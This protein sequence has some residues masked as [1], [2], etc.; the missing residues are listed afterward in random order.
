MARSTP[1]PPPY[2]QPLTVIFLGAGASAADGA[3][4]QSKLFPDY[5]QSAAIQNRVDAEMKAAL[6]T[7]F[8]RL[9]GIDVEGGLADARFPT[10]EEVLGMLDIAEARGEAFRGFGDDPHA[11][12]LRELRNHLVALISLIL[13]EKLQGEC[14]NHR[15]L[16]QSLRSS[17]RLESASFVSLNYD[18]LI[19]NAIERASIDDGRQAL[20]DYG[21]EFTPQ[22]NRN[23]HPFPVAS[24]LL[25]LHG[26]L[27]WLHCPTCNA[28]ALFPHH[29]V[30]ADLPGGPWH[31]R[32]SVCHELQQPI[33][34]PPTF[35][36]VMSNFFLQQIW[37][38]AEEELRRAGRIV[39]CG[40]SFPDADLH[41]KYLLKRAEVNRNGEA[42]RVFIVNEHKNKNDE[43][44]RTERERYARFF[45]RKNDVIWVNAS[46]EDFADRP[47][48]VDD[49]ARC[50]PL[51]PGG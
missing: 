47:N 38:R 46:F 11:T 7:Y 43:A 30:A 12:G 23:G 33:L 18:I 41:V 25:K 1:I 27:N 31:F 13:Q 28:L 19:D 2:D 5:F 34:I 26:S 22:P 42:P 4:I 37:K 21:V 49:K 29:K 51:E 9:W 35:F 44:R 10:F 48:V 6:R 16:V 24:R 40:Y 14:P 36:K 20:P 50:E 3:P 15:R 17:G 39:F 45:R 32:C 8:N